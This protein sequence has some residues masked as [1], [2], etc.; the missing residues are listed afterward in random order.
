MDE[1]DILQRAYRDLVMEQK[2]GRPSPKKLH[3]KAVLLWVMWR[4]I[5]IQTWAEST[6]AHVP[7]ER[8]R[9]LFD[10]VDDLLF[11]TQE[12]DD[13]EMPDDEFVPEYVAWGLACLRWRHR[14]DNGRELGGF[15]LSEAEVEVWLA[16][17][18]WIPVS[19]NPN[20]RSLFE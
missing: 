10:K 8:L 14:V 13:W 16:K 6:Y 17:R 12:T 9:Y 5:S 20:Q 19:S 4:D 7:H 11:D 15:H 2:V 1:W 3:M 18:E